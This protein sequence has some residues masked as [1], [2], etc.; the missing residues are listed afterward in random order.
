M[1]DLLS[2][3]AN[4]L[5]DILNIHFDI[6]A[7]I[8]INERGYRAGNEDTANIVIDYKIGN[9]YADQ[10]DISNN[11]ELTVEFENIY[12]NQNK[13]NLNYQ[14]IEHPWAGGSGKLLSKDEVLEERNKRI[15]EEINFAF[16]YYEKLKTQNTNSELTTVFDAYSIDL[17]NSAWKNT[18]LPLSQ[19]DLI[20]L[21]LPVREIDERLLIKYFR[22]SPNIW[23]NTSDFK[24]FLPVFL[25]C[26]VNHAY[27]P[28]EVISFINKLVAANFHTW[29]E[30]EKQ[31]VIE[32]L[33]RWWDADSNRLVLPENT[34]E[35]ICA[36][37]KIM[38]VVPLLKKLWDKP[39]YGGCMRLSELANSY[40]AKIELL[41]N[42][43]IETEIKEFLKNPKTEETIFLR[44][45]KF[46]EDLNYSN[47]FKALE[48]IT[49][50]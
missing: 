40:S 33:E 43:N 6:S 8:K 2:G 1:N 18:E 21:G 14:L 31:A 39:F 4:H 25:F 34:I 12:F 42:E 27:S 50:L 28:F 49:I 45:E 48:Q 9:Y 29:L 44:A 13:W 30:H 26:I 5:V 22:N 35:K 46:K 47:Y 17:Q 7:G 38:D 11:W 24:H 19:L 3:I 10:F 15:I 37:S 32:A 41:Q 36:L 20:V 16:L 23:G